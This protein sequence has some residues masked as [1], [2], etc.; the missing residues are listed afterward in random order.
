MAYTINKN[1]AKA[2]IDQMP[3]DATWDDLINEICLRIAVERG[4]A[5]VAAGRVKNMN[6]VMREYGLPE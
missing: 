6:E 1:D 3:D 5:D 4:L 2:L